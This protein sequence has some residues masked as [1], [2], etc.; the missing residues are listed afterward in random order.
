MT[1]RVVH[2]LVLLLLV[3]GAAVLPGAMASADD[4]VDTTAPQVQ[5][6][7]CFE[8]TGCRLVRAAVH[9]DLEPGDDLAVLGARIGDQVLAEHVFDDGSGFVP[10]GP[11]WSYGSDVGFLVDYA[12]SVEVP[13]GSSDITFYARD[14]EGNSS[15]LTTTVLGPVPPG[16][17]RR[18]T[19]RLSGHRTAQVSW[20]P[21]SRAG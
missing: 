17:V 20:G 3:A 11:Y 14:L 16:P 18:L 13:R 19:A 1:T 21:A 10:Y 7:P 12:L 6:N 9:G 2:A 15:E 5:L 8:G 4:E